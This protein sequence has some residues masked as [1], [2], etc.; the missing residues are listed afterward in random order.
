MVCRQVHTKNE[1]CSYCL[2]QA[3]VRKA[4]KQGKK[5]KPKKKEPK[6]TKA[7][8]KAYVEAAQRVHT[9]EGTCEIDDGATVSW[10]PGNGGCYVQGWLWVNDED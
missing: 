1:I 6:L 7:Q 10:A 9:D 8:E 5:P 3:N 2:A 4:V